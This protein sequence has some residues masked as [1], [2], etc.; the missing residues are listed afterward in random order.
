MSTKAA[1]EYLRSIYFATTFV[2]LAA[3]KVPLDSILFCNYH[4]TDCDAMQ[5]CL[6][7]RVGYYT[8]IF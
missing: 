5:F 7:F 4:R 3:D 6:I 2:H 8:A 1:I